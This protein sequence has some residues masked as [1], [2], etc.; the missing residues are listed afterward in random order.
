MF[1]ERFFDFT[2]IKEHSLRRNTD[3]IERT[4]LLHNTNFD[5]CTIRQLIP[6]VHLPLKIFVLCECLLSGSGL[7]GSTGIVFAHCLHGIANIRIVSVKRANVIRRRFD[8][9]L[10]KHKIPLVLP[11]D[12][13]T[14]IS[15]LF[16]P[17]DDLFLRLRVGLLADSV[18]PAHIQIDRFSRFAVGQAVHTA[19]AVDRVV[20]NNLR[21]TVSVDSFAG[22]CRFVLPVSEPANKLLRLRLILNFQ[23]DF[24]RNAV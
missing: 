19:A 2:H 16:C 12:H 21:R 5:A 7:S 22:I 10:C 23:V 24:F 8:L 1:C 18:R 11:C 6:S 9:R 17:A 13:N 4:V 14:V 3:T 15:L 20:I